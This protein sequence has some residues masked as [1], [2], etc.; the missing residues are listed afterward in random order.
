VQ[1][2]PLAVLVAVLIG[3]ELAGVL[4]ALAAIPVAGAIQ[5]VIVDWNRHR[6]ERLVARPSEPDL[7]T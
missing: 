1:L 5:V 3:A 6:L 7:T 4:G 2:S